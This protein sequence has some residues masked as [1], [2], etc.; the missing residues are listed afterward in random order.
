M[1]G[2]KKTGSI[3]LIENSK[4]MMDGKNEHP[5]DYATFMCT[6]RPVCLSRYFSVPK[7]T[8]EGGGWAM[9]I[10]WTIFHGT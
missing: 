9:E 1:N 10:K 6:H 8:G 3:I 4:K 5:R 2:G 7:R